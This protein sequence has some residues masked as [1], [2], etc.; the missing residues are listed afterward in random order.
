MTTIN[1]AE[2]TN[3]SLTTGMDGNK[4]MTN[5]TKAS[6]IKTAMAIVPRIRSGL[7]GVISH[8]S[9]AVIDV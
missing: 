5:I 3:A 6:P 9:F 4:A 8:A 2:S 7:C 1:M